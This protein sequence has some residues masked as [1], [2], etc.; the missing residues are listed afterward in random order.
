MKQIEVKNLTKIYGRASKKALKMLFQG[1]DKHEIL[2][3]TG[4]TVGVNR[5]SFAINSGEIFVIMGLSGSGK[6]T[7]LR[8]LNRLIE[9]TAGQVLLDGEDLVEMPADKLREIRRKRIGMVFQKFA[10]FPHRTVIE[11]VEFGLEIQGMDGKTRREKAWESL[12]LVGLENYADSLPDQLSGGMQQR[13]G[14]ARALANN[15]DIL[16]MDEAFSALDPLI[17]K[18]M[19]DELL[20]LQRNMNKTIIFITHDLDEALRIGD[21]IV[22]MRDGEVVQIGTPE[23]ILTNPADE[24]VERFVEDVNL[25]KVLMAE[26]IMQKPEVVVLG[27]DGPRVALTRIRDKRIPTLLVIDRNREVKGLLTAD[28]VKQAVAQNMKIEEVMIEDIVKVQKDTP[29]Q[30]VLASMVQMDFSY[31][32]VVVDDKERLQGIVGRGALL[33]ALAGQGGDTA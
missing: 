32:A 19:Q 18:D 6:S 21:R 8:M 24:Y 4:A 31:P 10:L 22:L 1:K 2:K 14:L 13:V 20:E 33:S 23:E 11:N 17:R 9:P 28:K 15:P 12:K 25:G 7:L 27:K 5:A 30:E 16:L 3:E 29:L 26:S